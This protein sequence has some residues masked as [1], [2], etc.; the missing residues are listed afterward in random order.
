MPAPRRASSGDPAAGGPDLLDAE[1]K[2]RDQRLDDDP[3]AHL[4]LPTRRS[5]KVI[6]SPD[7]SPAAI[8]PERLSIW[9]T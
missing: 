7:A 8:G 3:A 5:R 2:R 4:G 6:G 1:L 9:K